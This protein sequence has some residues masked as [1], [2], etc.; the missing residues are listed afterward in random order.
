M[1][2]ALLLLNSCIMVVVLLSSS[3]GVVGWLLRRFIGWLAGPAEL[4]EP[5]RRTHRVDQWNPD[6]PL[7]SARAGQ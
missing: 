6:H 3:I 1:Y 4:A 7:F 5:R 2:Y